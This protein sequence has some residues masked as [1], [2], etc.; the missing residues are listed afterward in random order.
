MC[1]NLN[2]PSTQLQ[3]K[4]MG[5]MYNFYFYDSL[6]DIVFDTVVF[7]YRLFAPKNETSKLLLYLFFQFYC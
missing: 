2:Q 5:S 7:L 6:G 3:L 4:V 1:E